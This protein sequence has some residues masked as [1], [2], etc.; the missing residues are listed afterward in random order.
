MRPVECLV[1]GIRLSWSGAIDVVDGD[2]EPLGQIVIS[3]G[4]IAWATHC[5]QSETLGVFLWRLGRITRAQLNQVGEIYHAHKGKKKLGAI[6]EE[7]GLVSRP[8]LRRCLLLHLRAALDA[9][10]A[11]PEALA[12]MAPGPRIPDEPFLFGLGEIISPMTRQH[13]LQA[14]VEEMDIDLGWQES[15][16]TLNRENLVLRGLTSLPGYLASAVLSFDGDVVVAHNTGVNM[17]LASFGVMAAAVLEGAARAAGTS[18]LGRLG[19]VSLRCDHGLL[20]ASWLDSDRYYF[21]CVLT[22]DRRDPLRVA[23]GLESALPA[24]CDSLLPDTTPASEPV[25]TRLAARA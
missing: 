14:L 25:A 20:S 11:E 10:L 9:V 1:R 4:R 13:E 19:T 21:V 6:L 24:L 15:W 3:D 8:V 18:P 5:R 22:R 17:D 2:G 23:T 12:R 16:F 7:A